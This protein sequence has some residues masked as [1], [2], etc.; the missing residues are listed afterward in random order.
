MTPV[1]ADAPCADS[2]QLA[3]SAK[4]PLLPVVGRPSCLA[5]FFSRREAPVVDMFVAVGPFRPVNATRQPSRAARSLVS[6]Y[7]CRNSEEG[8]FDVL[9]TSS[10]P[11]LQPESSTILVYVPAD[12]DTHAPYFPY[13]S[14]RLTLILQVYF[15]S[16]SFFAYL[17]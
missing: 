6:Q 1:A 17:D 5:R 3:G 12:S 13:A 7:K 2:A 8:M 10:V 16:P 14:T 15:R 9:L 4:S 11:L